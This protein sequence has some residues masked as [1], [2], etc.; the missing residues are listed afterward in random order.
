MFE[1]NLKKK[2]EYSK[3]LEYKCAKMMK[4]GTIKS[5][6]HRLGNIEFDKNEFCS[7]RNKTYLVLDLG[8]KN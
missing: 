7:R 4:D 6:C 3:S 1:L 2:F 5:N 8:M